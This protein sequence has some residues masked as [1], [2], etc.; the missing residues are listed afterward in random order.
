MIAVFP[1]PT[2]F[3]L[4]DDTFIYRCSKKAPGSTI[5]HQHRNKPKLDAANLLLRVIAP[6]FAGQR[7]I[8]L[9][10]NWFMI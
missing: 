7:V 3:F 1:Q 2:W 9:V 5:H 8:F 6:V 10:D 4:F